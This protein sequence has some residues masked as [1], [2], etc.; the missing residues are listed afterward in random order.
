ML[1]VAGFLS[2][3]LSAEEVQNQASPRDHQLTNQ[4]GYLEAEYIYDQASFPSCHASTIAETPSGLVAAWFGGSD[5]GEPDVGIWVS[6]HN[7]SHW[8]APMEVAN[9]IQYQS[10]KATHRHPCWNPVL[11]QSNQGSL[12]LFYKVGPNPEQWWGMLTT[13]TDGGKTWDQPHRLPE[14]ID[15][16][17]KNKPIVLSGGDLLCGSSTEYDGWR[18]H[19]ERTS[20]WGKTW[21]RIGPLRGR[22]VAGRENEA[23]QPSILTH[24]NNRLQL[25]CRN[26]K[27]RGQ[28]LE[29]WSSD[30]GAT[31]SDLSETTL[32]NPNSGTD[33]VT[34]ADG[35]QLLVYNHTHRGSSFPSGRNMLNVAVSADGTHWQAALLLERQPG[36]YSY[37][38]VIQ[39]SDG[40]VHITYTWQRKKIRHVVVDPRR[41][42]PV[43]MQEN[44][45]PQDHLGAIGPE[46]PKR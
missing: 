39:S 38:A 37:P 32:P 43:E 10:E 15:G 21:H 42:L 1:L 30:G 27:G 6:R 12:L 22:K 16:P 28:I 44:H 5:E 7:G 24:S 29:A 41:L 8:S 33:A 2:M 35:R 11:F 40:L 23:I 13:S 3:P 26:H 18:I 25:L 20:D 17:V 19:L 4:P 34:L 36:E 14:G 45:W 9:G 46:G 31:W